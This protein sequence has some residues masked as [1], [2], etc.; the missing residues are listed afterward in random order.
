MWVPLNMVS[1]RLF[2]TQMYVFC[3]HSSD[4]AV[5]AAMMAMVVSTW[6]RCDDVV[7]IQIYAFCFSRRMNN[8]HFKT[9][10]D[11]FIIIL[12]SLA[13]CTVYCVV[14]THP[15]RAHFLTYESACS[16]C[17]PSFEQQNMFIYEWCSFYRLTVLGTKS[18]ALDSCS[19]I[20]TSVSTTQSSF[21]CWIC[22]SRME[23]LGRFPIHMLSSLPWRNKFSV[24]FVLTCYAN[25]NIEATK[26][27]PV[28]QTK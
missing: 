5:M 25:K 21:L 2:K 11:H 19:R 23:R 9:D 7:I 8:L 12:Y 28:I 20:W 13:V 16:A 6:Q 26:R 15:N 3:I 27:R 17:V 14:C 24:N 10:R 18:T 4:G 1:I 22:V